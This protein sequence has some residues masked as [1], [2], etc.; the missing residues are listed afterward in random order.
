ME[1][2]TGRSFD[3]MLHAFCDQCWPPRPFILVLSPGRRVI[4]TICAILQKVQNHGLKRIQS[5]PKHGSKMRGGDLVDNPPC[6]HHEISPVA[7]KKKQLYIQGNSK[8]IRILPTTS[9]SLRKWTFLKTS[10]FFKLLQW[11]PP[12]LTFRQQPDSRLISHDFLMISCD[13]YHG[14]WFSVISFGFLLS[15]YNHLIFFLWRSV[16]PHDFLWF[17]MIFYEFP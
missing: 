1:C 15:S 8:Q 9:N 3:T 13:C 10:V 6:H 4:F 16:I 11:I 5:C 12:P 7:V 14:L 2:V 17:A